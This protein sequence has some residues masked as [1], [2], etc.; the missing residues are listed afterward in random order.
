MNII[1]KPSPTLVGKVVS[2]SRDKTITILIE[3]KIKHPLIGK[4]VKR[5]K[6]IHA[7]DEKNEFHVGDLVLIEESRPIS[8]TKNWRAIALINKN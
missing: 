5:T 6:K 4:I 1:N 7:H 3:R 8:K 2:D